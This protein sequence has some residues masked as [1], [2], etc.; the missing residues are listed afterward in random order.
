MSHENTFQKRES[1]EM[2]HRENRE[3]EQAVFDQ[4][5]EFQRESL[6]NDIPDIQGDLDDLYEQLDG[7][8][9]DLSP[10]TRSRI[11]QF[12]QRAG[13][14]ARN[15]VLAASLTF[16]VPAYSNQDL[17]HPH[18]AVT[19]EDVTLQEMAASAQKKKGEPKSDAEMEQNIHAQEG[20]QE[21]KLERA[22]RFLAKEAITDPSMN[23]LVEKAS[24]GITENF[25]E[26]LQEELRSLSLESKNEY[27]FYVTENNNGKWEL[28]PMANMQNAVNEIAG[29][30]ISIGGGYVAFSISY[31][32]LIRQ[33]DLKKIYIMHNHNKHDLDT[34]RNTKITQGEYSIVDSDALYHPPSLVDLRGLSETMNAVNLPN[35]VIFSGK[36]STA[37][38]TWSYAKN[39]NGT[40]Y[41]EIQKAIFELPQDQKGIIMDFLL[42]NITQEEAEDY[43]EGVRSLLAVATKHSEGLGELENAF[44]QVRDDL[45]FGEGEQDELIEKTKGATKDLGFDLEYRAY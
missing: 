30:Q 41:D 11:E 4:P 19:D 45:V 24:E 8:Y 21:Q 3:N 28:I 29:K 34:I 31:E 16:P 10:Q 32:E 35:N 15:A 12:K 33:D 5:L 23:R 38:G 36:V 43:A 7:S 22:Y 37:D 2:L 27:V 1:I 44:M 20:M 17:L 26:E 14:L 25:E 40:R 9:E 39:E 18:E 42:E 6:V 13:K